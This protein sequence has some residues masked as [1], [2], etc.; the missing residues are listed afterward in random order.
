MP[1]LNSDSARFTGAATNLSASLRRT[2]QYF[3][4]TAQLG[5]HEADSWGFYPR[6]VRVNAAR[7]YHC[8]SMKPVSIAAA[9]F[10]DRLTGM[11][12]LLDL[13]G[14]SGHPARFKS[15]PSQGLQDRVLS[16]SV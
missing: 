8:T 12:W 15:Q 11:S 13:L 4:D 10:D 3:A 6:C 1:G 14:N 2:L 5:S 7:I 16:K 9:G